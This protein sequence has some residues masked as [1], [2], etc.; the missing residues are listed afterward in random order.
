MIIIWIVVAMC[1][2]SSL[3]LLSGR[4]GF[5]IAGYNTATQEEKKQYDE[6]KLCRVTGA[7]V[8]GITILTAVLGIWKEDTPDWY[9]IFYCIMDLEIVAVT[10]ILGNT[11]CKV[12]GAEKVKSKGNTKAVLIITG[13]MII[14]FSLMV[15]LFNRGEIEI[16]I[17]D[18]RIDIQG[19]L[20]S[21]Y[22]VKAEDIDSL[23][24][25]ENFD[26]G[27]KT[28]GF[29]S[30]KLLQG[31]FKNKEQGKY[32]LYVYKKCEEY[33]ILHTKKGDVVI[34]EKTERETKELYQEITDMK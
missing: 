1:G 7:G 12:R 26:V 16:Q 3:L 17:S 14:S 20:W 31:E 9:W 6:K 10:M 15:I 27:K 23:E 34:N 4:G 11:V 33:I 5:L 19:Y 29:S 13:L 8:L 22:Q 30:S 21:D 28:N 32:T 18:N 24:L 25:T 2:I